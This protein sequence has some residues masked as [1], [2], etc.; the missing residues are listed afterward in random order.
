MFRP[1]IQKTRVLF[2]IALFNLSMVYFAANSYIKVKQIGYNDKIEAVENMNMCLQSIKNHPNYVY[3]AEDIFNSG[4][5]GVQ[6]SLITT[7]EDVDLTKKKS[8]IACTNPNFSA[9]IIEMFYESGIQEGDYIAV[10]MTGSFPGANIALLSACKAMNVKP[11]IISSSGS[12]AWGAN[13]PDFSWPI[14]ESYLYKNKMIDYKS[15][16]YSIGGANDLGDNLSYQGVEIISNAIFDILDSKTE[17]VNETTLSEN[18][19]RKIEIYNSHL[20]IND[21]NLYVNI[22]G[23]SASLGYGEQKDTM[24][25]GLISPLDIEFYQSEEFKKS[26]AYEFLKKGVPML[27]IKNI[28]KLGSQYELYPPNKDSKIKEGIIFVK[29]VRYN[30][31]VII[32]GLVCSISLILFI[33][34]YSHLQIK[35]RMEGHEPESIM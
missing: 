12:S 32:V 34:I 31:F 22:G 33:G 25:V 8:K 11:F 29:Y 18:I 15:L 19:E 28:N 4:L 6:T 30:L 9:A 27:N 35:R 3:N 23:G 13:R 5:L 20:K 16:A 2:L 21:Y 26:I 24:D 1:Q 14:M 10:S 7:K 17:F